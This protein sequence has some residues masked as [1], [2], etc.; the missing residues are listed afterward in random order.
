MRKPPSEMTVP[1]MAMLGVLGASV[2]AGMFQIS[3]DAASAFRSVTGAAD[4][5]TNSGSGVSFMSKLS[6]ACPIS[7]GKNDKSADGS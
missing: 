5:A 2:S 7:W 1:E 3:L 6:A 4:D